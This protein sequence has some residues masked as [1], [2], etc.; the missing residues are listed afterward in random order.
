VK[1]LNG[2]TQ[3]GSKDRMANIFPPAFGA[4]DCAI[5]IRDAV[6]QHLGIH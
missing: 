2:I 5:K 6:E 4:V 3:K 1:L